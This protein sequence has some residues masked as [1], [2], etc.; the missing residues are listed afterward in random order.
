M[1]QSFWGPENR[2]KTAT[3][4][5][6]PVFLLPFHTVCHKQVFGKAK[7]AEGSKCKWEQFLFAFSLF[8]EFLFQNAFLSN[9]L[10]Y[11]QYTLNIFLF[12]SPF[13]IGFFLFPFLSFRPL[14]LLTAF[15][16]FSLSL[17][18]PPNSLY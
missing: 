15:F 7:K 3:N 17:S 1:R 11:S 16:F 12:L 8:F 4:N 10:L 5:C 2:E 6:K 9:S 14:L 18:L 13:Q